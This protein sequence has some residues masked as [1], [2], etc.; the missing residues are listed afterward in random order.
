VVLFPVLKRQSETAALGLVTARVVETS[1]IL[2][3]VA[4]LLSMVGLRTDAAGTSGANS[5]ALAVTGHSLL[6]F[7][8]GAFLVS[9]SLMPVICDL[10][11]GYL[12]Y[13]SRLV[14]RI[15]PRIAFVGAP[16]LLASDLAIFFGVYDRAAAAATLAAFPI[17][18][19]ELSVGIW[20]LVKG[21]NPASPLLAKPTADFRSPELKP[22]PASTPF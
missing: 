6:G 19:F 13:R 2:V 11:L 3:S 7:Y 5:S 21:F 9:Q 18:A 15:L 16:I 12:L 22:S 17:A 8:N 20:L 14:P 1:L 4:S 10:L